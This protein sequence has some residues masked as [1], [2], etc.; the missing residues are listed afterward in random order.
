MK[1]T[2]FIGLF[3]LTLGLFFISCQGD[4]ATETKADSKEQVVEDATPV[5]RKNVK[6]PGINRDSAHQFVLDQLTFGPRVPNSIGHQNTKAWIVDRL[7]SYGVKVTEQDF[8]VEDYKGTTLN[9]TNIIG[10]INPDHTKRVVLAAHWDTRFMAD[11]DPQRIEDPI[12]GADDGASG[13]AVLL[14]IARTIQLNPIDMGVDLIFFDVEDQGQAQG[15]I[16]T[17][18]MGS[19]Y[20]AQNPHV[21]GYRAKYGILLDMVGAKGAIFQTENL[22]GVFDAQK[23]REITRLYDK[24]WNLAQAMGRGNMFL[25]RKINAL[26][27]DHYFVNLHTNI[28]MIDIVN[29][30]I[31]S[32]TGFGPH[33]HTHQ[34]EFSVIDKNVLGIVGQLVT[35]VIYKESGNNF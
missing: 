1:K 18:C 2:T 31:E 33:W 32:A 34:D 28:P 8:K 35:A 12:A 24:V 20:W 25:N 22:S 5:E 23:V 17:W 14:E 10:A 7:K 15:K 16:E 13:V 19:Q 4:E 9:A 21:N 27:D 29:R 11:Q 26:T 6:V 3:F 30:P